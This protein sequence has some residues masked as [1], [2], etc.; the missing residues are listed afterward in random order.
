[1]AKNYKLSDEEKEK[2][3]SLLSQIN[4]RGNK[5]TSEKAETTVKED[6]GKTINNKQPVYRQSNIITRLPTAKVSYNNPENMQYISRSDI[7]ARIEAEKIDEDIKKGGH[8]AVNARIAN[9]GRNFLGGVQQGVAGIG[10]AIILPVATALKNQSDTAKKMGFANSNKE[11]GIDRVVNSLLDASKSLTDGSSFYGKIN[12]NINDE[13]T[14]NIGSVTN[15]LGNM[16]PSI[17]SNIVLPGSGLVVAGISAGGNSAQ[18]AI[19]ND[20]TN[21]NQAILTGTAKGAVETLT[22]KLTG[23]NVLSKGSLDDFVGKTISSKVKSDIGKKIANKAYQFAGEMLEEQISDNA[24]YLIDKVINQKDLPD[25]EEW[26]NQAGETNKITFLSTLAL[27]LVG[28]GGSNVENVDTETQQM[29]NK[30]AEKAN[31]DPEM[32]RRIQSTINNINNERN[33]NNQTENNVLPTA[34]DIDQNIENFS[35]L[36]KQDMAGTTDNI[37]NDIQNNKIIQQKEQIKADSENFSKQIDEVKNGTFPKNDMLVLGRTPQVL[38]DIG[39]SDLPITMTQKHLDTIMNESGKYK[40]ASYHGLGEEIVKQLP[41]AINNPLDIV[42]SKTRDDSIVLT[43]YLAD[44][45]NRTVIASIKIDGKGTVNDIRIDTNVMTSAYGRNNYEKFMEDNIKN[46][47][48]LYDIDRGVIKKV[49]GARLQ[50]PRRSN[51][52]DSYESNISNSITQTNRNVK[53]NTNTINNSMQNSE[54]DNTLPIKNKEYS[55]INQAFEQSAKKNNIDPNNETI[56][57]IKRVTQERGIKATFDEDVFNGNDNINA[58]WKSN[59]DGTREIILNP[60]KNQQKAD[61]D[62]TLQNVITHEL[63]HDLE[64]TDEYKQLRDLILNYNENKTG[65]TEARKSLEEIYSRVYDKNGEN[66][67]TLVDSEAIADILGNKLGDQEFINN[68]TTEK[69]SLGRRIY[70]W[71]V[72]KLNKINKLSGYKNEKLFW[73]DV[74][75]KFE[76]AYRQD[77]Q[78]N[79]HEAKF[80]VVYNKDGSFNR[81]KID[82]NIFE[83]NDNKSI[84]KTIKDY[85]TKHIGEYADI[86]ESGQRV[87][88]GEDLPGEYAFSQSAQGL[89]LAQKMAK[90]RAT[91]GLKEIINNATNRKYSKNKKEKH[92]VDAKY[93]FYKYDTKFSFKVKGKEQ[94]YSGTILIR[95]DTDGKKYLYDILN[96]KKIGSNLPSVASNSKKSSAMI[97]GS[98]SLPTNNSITSSN[99]NVNTTKYSIQESESNSG[100]FSVQDNQGRKLSK[101]QQARYKNVSPKLKDE[102]GNLKRYYHGTQRSDRVGNYF[103]P[104]RATS[105]PMAFFTDN[106]DIAKN[107]SENKQD[108]SISREANTEYDLFKADGKNLDDYW[109]SLSKEQQNKIAQEGYNIGLD[110][111]FENIVHEKD[112]SK[113]SFSTQYDYYLNHEEKGNAVKALYDVFIQDGNLMFEDMAKFQ[114]V[115]KYAGVQNVEYLDQYTTSPKVYEVYLNITNPFDTSE[116]SSDIVQKLKNKAKTIDNQ[117]LGYSADQWDKSNITPE[118]WIARLEDD[119]K[120]GTTHAWTSIPDWVTDVLKENGY[121]G[122]VDTGG[123]NGGEEH[124]VAIPFYSNQI[125]NIDNTNPTDNPDIRYSQDNNN[126]QSFLDKNYKNE[127]EGQ[128]IQEVKEQSRKTLNPTEIANL[129]PEDASTTPKLKKKTYAKGNK[130]SSFFSNITEKSKFLNEDFRDAMKQDENIEYYKTVSNKETLE[131]AYNKLQEDGQ[132]EVMRWH[133]KDS[134]KAT[135]E[136]VAEGWILL[137]QYQDAGDYDSAVEVAKKMRDIGTTAGQTVQAYNI[138]SRLTPEGMFYYAQGELSEAYSKMVEGKSKKWIDENKSKFDLTPEETQF[139]LDTMQDV[140][141]MEDGYQ[142][143]VKLAEIQKVITDK[144]PATTGQSIKAWMRISMLFNPKTQV[145]NVMGNA[146]ITPVNMFSDSVSAGIDRLISKKTGV[147]TTGNL[148]LKSYGKGFGKGLYESYNDFKKG[149]NTR[150]IEGNRFEVSEGKSFNDKG[151]GKVLNRVD[152]LLSFMLDAGDRGFYEAT[153]TNSINNQ[154]VLNNTKEVTQ[155]MIDIATTE[156]LQRTWQDNNNYT[157]TVLGIRKIL[158]NVNIKGYGLGDVLIPFAKTPANLTKAIVDYSPAGLVKTLTSDAIKLKNSLENGQ[159][160]PQLQHQFVQNLGKAT[161]GSFLYVLGYALAQA[162]VITGEADEDKDVKNFMKNSLG[163][164][165]YSIKIGDKSFSYDWAQ[166]IATPFAIMANYVKYSNDNPEASAIDKAINAMNIGTEQLLQQSF[167]ESLNTVLNGSD[168]TLENLSQAVL[169]LPSRAIPTFSKQIA[170]MIDSTQRTSFEYD[171]PMQSAINSVIAKIPFASKT[172]P[173]S[174]DT[175]GNEIK[176]YGGD[177]NVFNVFL[178]P[179]NM[180]K[181]ELSKAGE[182]IYNIYKETGDNTIFPRTAPYYINNKGEK[183]TMTAR[184]RSEFQKI[185]GSYVED[186]L[187]GLL[188]NKDYKKLSNEEKGKLI[189]EIV[190]DSYSKARYDVLKLDSE[191]YKKLRETL[192]TVKAT[193]YYDY[194]SKIEESKTD[195]DKIEILANAKYADKEKITLYETY[196]LS[197]SDAKYPIIKETFTKNGLNITK[198]LKYKAQEFT[199]DKEDDGT[200]SGKSISGSK[201]EKVVNYIDSIEGA[202]YTQKLILLGLEYSLSD[203]EKSQIVN[204][205]DSLEKTDKEKLDILGNFK[206]FTIY[207]DG[208]FDY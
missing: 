185:S 89:T 205:I 48:L 60:K 183:V 126:W 42:K 152:N 22:E 174:I 19:N 79:N 181:G 108:T 76:N 94:V 116:I 55:Y 16:A 51:F 104:E 87:Y 68:L 115:L 133:S 203:Y 74:K 13:L 206:G 204:Y 167:M 142:K 77:Y 159:Y 131:K 184:E 56:K 198:Y 202:T 95:N 160:T 34:R 119:I 69:P 98:N 162:G 147:R 8:Y 92:N 40:N 207:K 146:V 27:N 164:N 113:N 169:E 194:T 32:Q 73:T 149:I 193:N 156:A 201:K 105:G 84:T 154:L 15:V 117:T 18:E 52:L 101:Q 187:S 179:A 135:S 107:Y 96:I 166:P 123:K 190:S 31:D 78:G 132:E 163:I 180:N 109:N 178:N 62:K 36:N 139:I 63:T 86:I 145:R 91:T 25:F 71:V 175:L 26:W 35:K 138:L 33:T 155:E 23:G 150:N 82:D 20:R 171:E 188:N 196:I 64:G 168:T 37:N 157:K 29:V 99:K 1:M 127:G 75:N 81:V 7:N 14:R 10:N 57:S 93:G 195:K 50:L 46:G 30:V 199:S 11:N 54:N 85:L 45:N 61:T 111:D 53:N 148:N 143:K 88:L 144:I 129:K 2:A 125:K 70:N 65:Y 122:I 43:T 44:K 49:T 59:D 173:A 118:Q 140:S 102:K 41:E 137:K 141:K 121:D 66:F 5:I 165:S 136:D 186:T 6:D 112:A 197:D 182:E 200:V 100:S 90:G 3:K 38:K 4:N 192:R 177:N 28:L 110:E 191:G 176:K 97:D 130:Q 72:D 47:N 80:S 161:A 124:Q 153:F 172:L 128:T 151:L 21:L 83:N 170:D 103:D 114:D 120:N 17:A 134:K 189:N 208:T 39:L 12:S 58:V 67:K 158:N 9:A 24:G 106:Q